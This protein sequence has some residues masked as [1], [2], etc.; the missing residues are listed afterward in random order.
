MV[1]ILVC[2]PFVVFLIPLLL[3]EDYW[4]DEFAQDIA[5]FYL[6]YY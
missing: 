6:T 4:G 2:L 1:W 3:G 5:E